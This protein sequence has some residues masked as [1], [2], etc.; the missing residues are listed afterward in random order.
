MSKNKVGNKEIYVQF[1][2]SSILRKTM[3][4]LKEEYSSQDTNKLSHLETILKS[5]FRVFVI[6][7][8]K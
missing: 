1:R 5:P 8:R 2:T 7:R 3:V 6:L 4:I